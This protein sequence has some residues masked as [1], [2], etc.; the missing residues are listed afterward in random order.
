MNIVLEEAVSYRKPLPVTE[1]MLFTNGEGFPIC[2][3]CGITLERAYQHY[4]DRCGQCLDWKGF[5][6]AKVIRWKPKE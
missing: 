2:P 6:R 4:C 5:S 1:I 3:R